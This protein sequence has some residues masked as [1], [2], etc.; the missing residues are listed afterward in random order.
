MFSFNSKL[1][2]RVEDRSGLGSSSIG[3]YRLN[4]QGKREKK[5]ATS[6]PVLAMPT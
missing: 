3:G 1:V 4:F 2:N 5:I 6:A